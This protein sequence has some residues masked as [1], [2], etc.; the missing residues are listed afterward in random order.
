MENL[1]RKCYWNIFME[2]RHEFL[3]ITPFFKK[4]A[5]GWKIKIFTVLLEIWSKTE[6]GKKYSEHQAAEKGRVNIKGQNASFKLVVID[7]GCGYENLLT[8]SNPFWSQTSLR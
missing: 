7:P 6:N 3:S 4:C 1:Y 8:E 2:V 5:E